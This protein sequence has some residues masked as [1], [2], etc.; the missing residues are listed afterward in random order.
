MS[1]S[2]G[3]IITT[4]DASDFDGFMALP[5][6]YK[7]AKKHNMDVMFIMNFPAY[8]GK[9]DVEQTSDHDRRADLG[10]GFDYP[11]THFAAVKGVKKKIEDLV[12]SIFECIGKYELPD[13]I[14]SSPIS[15]ETKP[16]YA[17]AYTLGHRSF[18]NTEM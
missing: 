18:G 15:L 2:R 11:Y 17:M 13:V 8:F 12:P 9:P 7:A 6:Y 10:L 1:S 4:G 14:P 16:M 3:L 5:L